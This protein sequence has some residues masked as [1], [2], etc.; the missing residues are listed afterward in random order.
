VAVFLWIFFVIMPL[1]LAAGF[2][3]KL[4]AE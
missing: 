1:V 4:F 2:T 3:T